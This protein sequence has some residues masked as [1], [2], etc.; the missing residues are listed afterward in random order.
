MALLGI[1]ELNLIDTYFD[2][3]ELSEEDKKN[4]VDLCEDLFYIY[5][6]VFALIST[7][8]RLRKPIDIK[9][10]TDKLAERFKD[11]LDATEYAKVVIDEEIANYIDEIS[12]NL[13]ESTLRNLPVEDEE[14]NL[15]DIV[16]PASPYWSSTER[17]I[18]VAEDMTN[19]IANYKELQDKIAEGYTHKTWVSILD[20]HTRESHWLAWG[21]TVPI[22][23][24]FTIGSSLMMCPCDHTAPAREIVNCRCRLIYSNDKNYGVN[25]LFASGGNIKFDILK[26]DKEAV[27]Y[28]ENTR[29]RND[30]VLKISNNTSFSYE[31]IEIIKNHI[32]VNKHLLDDGYRRYDADRDMAVAWQRLINGRYENRDITLLNHELVEND[33]EKAYNMPYREAH[34]LANERYN[35]EKEIE[36]LPEG[37]EDVSLDD[38]IKEEGR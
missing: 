31:Q 1:D 21:K 14:D 15:D 12:K 9:E 38:L 4:R 10:Y 27:D 16:R 36:E 33:L 37:Y 2:E 8:F 22:N 19:V 29:R 6:Y 35:W 7:D 26:F 5:Y 13:V 24:P 11:V 32:F 28:Y 20:T 34:V 18:R 3:M 17:A 30:D 23:K 25:S